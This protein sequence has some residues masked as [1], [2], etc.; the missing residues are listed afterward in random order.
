VVIV[1]TDGSIAAGD[2]SEQAIIEALIRTGVY[3]A[4]NAVGL[5]LDYENKAIDR[6]QE[7]TSTT[8]F[9]NY[10]M[11]GGRKRCNVNDN[12][13][14]TAFYGDSNYKEDGSNG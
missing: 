8:N 7:S 3:H 4:K 10:S 14:I 13:T 12:G 2:T 11:Y 6:T 9:N 1:G 5:G